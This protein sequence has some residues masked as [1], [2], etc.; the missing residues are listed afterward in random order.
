MAKRFLGNTGWLLTTNIYSMILSLV[1]GSLSARYLGP[2]NYGLIGY[3]TSLIMLFTSISKLGLDSV[4]INELVV[5]PAKKGNYLGAALVMRLIASIISIVCVSIFVSIMEPGNSLLLEITFLQSIAILFQVHEIFNYWFQAELKSKYFVIAS[6]VAL[7]ASAVWRIFLLYN[8]AS[9]KWFALSISIQALVILIV[10][11]I[12]FFQK[13]PITLRVHL[14]DIK[15]LI[16]KSRHF[17]VANLAIT[18]YMQTDKIMIGK[19][20]GEEAVGFYTAAM[21]IA[22]IWQFVPNA[23]INSSYSLIISERLN[24]PKTYIKRLQMLMLT[25]T[26]LGIIVGIV[27][28]MFGRWAILALYGVAY[29]QSIIT[30]YILIWSTGLAVL[31]SA[32][33]IWIVAEGL[34]AYQKYMVLIGG[35]I[36]VVLN[37]F[38]IKL[39]GINGAAIATLASQLA[40]QFIAPLCFKKTRPLAGVYWQSFKLLKTINHKKIQKEIKNQLKVG[41]K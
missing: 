30:L 29:E 9:V 11:A 18:I 23:I 10:T 38:T 2:S 37:L 27:I 15:Y 21:T 1:I 32:R 35:V 31:G 14:N 25:I 24:N 6:C 33:G 4:V 8:G 5:N 16:S 13:A 22:M 17:I 26:L 40:V 39:F 36:N 34:N 19:M 3:G 28:L 20:L 7:T 41:Q 12:I